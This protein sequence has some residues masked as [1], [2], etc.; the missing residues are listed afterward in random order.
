MAFVSWFM[1][2][3]TSALTAASGDV[4][5][6]SSTADTQTGS[7]KLNANAIIRI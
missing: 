4:K 5:V 1:A 7:A 3:V 2:A 6:C